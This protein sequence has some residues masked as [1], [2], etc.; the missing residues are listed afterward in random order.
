MLLVAS[1]EVRGGVMSLSSLRGKII[2]G[3]NS[4]VQVYRWD[5]ISAGSS[6]VDDVALGPKE[7]NGVCLTLLRTSD[8][9]SLA[10]CV[11][12]LSVLLS[13][14]SAFPVNVITY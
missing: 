14:D 4:K 5:S 13:S 11:L 2:A 1:K 10:E 8:A 6:V 9:L 3:I 12:S 7:L